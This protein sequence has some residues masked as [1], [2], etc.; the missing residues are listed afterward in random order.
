MFDSS[1]LEILDRDECLRLLAFVPVGRIVFTHR[2]LPAVQPVNFV[3][4]GEAII[5]RT[6]PGSKMHGATH[7]TVVA[8]EA[9][10]INFDEHSGWSVT[11]VGH[12]SVVE[13]PDERRR[14]DALPLRPWAPGER[15]HFLRIPVDM[16]TGR[17]LHAGGARPDL[18]NRK[19]HLSRAVGE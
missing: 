16:V 11:V 10:D 15:D 3:V 6:V 9:D 18:A 8:F 17:R 13:D 12:A 7:D 2:A 4:D 14:L 19:R 5:I 1:G